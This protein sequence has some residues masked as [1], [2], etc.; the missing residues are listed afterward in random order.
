[1]FGLGILISYW[2][3][4]HNLILI[5]ESKDLIAF[6]SFHL[7]LQ[8][9]SIFILLVGEIVCLRVS[10]VMG[11]SYRVEAWVSKTPPFSVKGELRT[12]DR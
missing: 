6:A 10:L 3:C 1:M 7:D 5:L 9:F 8:G 4:C 2:S 12:W 11:H